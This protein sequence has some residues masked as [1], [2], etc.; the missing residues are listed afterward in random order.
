MDLQLSGRK[1]LV[2]GSSRGIGKAI[3]RAL[4]LEGCDVAICARSQDALDATAAELA[5]ET[6]R[7]IVPLACDLLDPASI[8]RFVDSSAEALGGLQIVVN[9]GARAGG[10]PGTV[11]TVTAE[12]VLLD[13][14]EKV[15]GYLRVVQAATPYMKAAGWGRVINISGGINRSPGSAIAGPVREI[16]TVTMTKAMAN[17]LGQYGITVNCV[18]PGLTLTEASLERHKATAEREGLPLD[19]V[20]QRIADRTAIKHLITAEEVAHVVT[21]LCSPL[22]VSITGESIAAMGG[23]SQDLHV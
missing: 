19:A 15:V 13:V 21:F 14:E 23:S 11:E 4:A 1:A 9:N 2:T 16:G 12:D 8:K 17:G 20:L 6:G 10:R 22:A 3:A 7:Q 18:T 5:K